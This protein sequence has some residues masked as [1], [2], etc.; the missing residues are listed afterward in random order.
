MLGVD[1]GG[2]GTYG[3]GTGH[4]DIQVKGV[5]LPDGPW[6]GQKAAHEREREEL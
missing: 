1:E 2:G 3:L 4:G 5:V 6:T